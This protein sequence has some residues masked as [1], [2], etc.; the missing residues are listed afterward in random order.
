MTNIERFILEN[1]V[2]LMEQGKPPDEIFHQ[3]DHNL[4][5]MGDDYVTYETAAVY[6]K[7]CI[8]DRDFR[9]QEKVNLQA[10]KKSIGSKTFVKRYPIKVRK[11]R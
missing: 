1:V 3:L 10:E 7:K 2:L 6:L 4:R 5:H 9:L 8:E 11:I